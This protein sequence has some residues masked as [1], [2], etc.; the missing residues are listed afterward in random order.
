[1]SE[2]VLAFDIGGTWLKVAEVTRAGEVLWDDRMPPY[3]DYRQD[4]ELIAGMIKRRSGDVVAAAFACPGPLDF[5]T[6][7]VFRAANLNW[8]NVFPGELLK[9]TLGMPVV[10]ENDADCAALA[11]A[12]YGSAQSSD[13]LVYYGLGTG[14]GAGVAQRRRIFHGAFDPEFGHQ[15]LEPK[16]D[17]YCTAG[18]RGCLESLI[19]G[20]GLERAFGTIAAVPD[21]QWTDVIPYY[22][23]QAMANATLF[24]SP[25][26]IA[27][28]GGVVDHRPDI[29]RPAVEVMNTMLNGFVVPPRVLTSKL[30][31]EVGILGAAAAAWQLTQHP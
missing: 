6:G 8:S 16:F 3:R 1:M 20:S 11:E 4:M 14:V 7:Q 31:R 13:M 10:V 2:S 18:H 15:F 27:I 5:R 30:G 22:L 17:R 29:V 21:E 12:V 19:S 23:G 24:L 28:G 25:D 9:Q 26:T